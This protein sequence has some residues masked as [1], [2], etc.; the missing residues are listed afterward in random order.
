[1]DGTRRLTTRD[2]QFTVLLQSITVIGV[3]KSKDDG[4]SDRGV[5]VHICGDVCEG[6]LR[7]ESLQRGSL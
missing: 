1:M 6:L 4:V 3:G 2:H 5:G 7:Q